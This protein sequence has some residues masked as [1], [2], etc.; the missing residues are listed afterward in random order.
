MKKTHQAVTGRGSIMGRYKE[1]IL[2]PGTVFDLLYFEFC[3]W[4]APLP[5]ALGMVLRKIFWPGL[6]ASCGKGVVFGTNIILRH[7]GRIKVG[8]RVVISENCILDGRSAAKAVTIE[9]GDDTILSNNVMLSCKEGGILLGEHC[10][11]NAQTIIQSTHD[12]PVVIG[13]D[14]IIGQKCFIV[15]GGSYQLT[16]CS[17]LIREEEIEPDGGVMLQGNVWL[18][19]QVTVLGGVTIGR[20]SVVGAGSVVTRSINE[21]SV[22]MGVPARVVRRRQR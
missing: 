12:C 15:G 17:R 19:G 9:L 3:Q 1:V 5:G 8:Q 13:P 18:G 20:G 4:L 10:G 14:C 7:P 2:G 11:I 22:C 16:D 6:F 21:Y